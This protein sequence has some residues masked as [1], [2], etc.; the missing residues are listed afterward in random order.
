MQHHP[1]LA[2]ADLPAFMAALRQAPDLTA[3]A[4]EFAIL[5]AA[6]TAEVLMADWS[7]LDL[8][9]RTWTVPAT[10]WK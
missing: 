4:L 7:E 3:R 5:T 10:Q 1:A 8:A 2:Y 6:R 9:A